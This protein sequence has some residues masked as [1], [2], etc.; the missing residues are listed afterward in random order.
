MADRDLRI[1]NKLKSYRLNKGITQKEFAEMLEMTQ[2]QLGAYENG[3]R[4]PRPDTIK[5]IADKMNISVEEFETTPTAPTG[6][7]P[8]Y[9]DLILDALEK[10]LPKGYKL[11]CEEDNGILYLKYPDGAVSTE[12]SIEQIQNIIQNVTDYCKFELNKLR[13]E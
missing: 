1:G 6:S 7:T 13:R 12:L 9:I 3:V 11:C 5:K 2:Q 10:N 8:E 4:I